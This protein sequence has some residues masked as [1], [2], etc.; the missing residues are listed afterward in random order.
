MVVISGFGIGLTFLNKIF[1]SFSGRNVISS[2]TRIRN[3]YSKIFEILEK[4]FSTMNKN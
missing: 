1:F 3:I 2:C 4:C